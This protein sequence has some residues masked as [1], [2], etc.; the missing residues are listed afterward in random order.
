MANFNFKHGLSINRQLKAKPNYDCQ[1]WRTLVPLSQYHQCTLSWSDK[2]A[3][4]ELGYDDLAQKFQMTKKPSNEL[5]EQLK[6]KIDECK[7]IL[8]GSN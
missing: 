5:K 2:C 6:K 8:E 3:H 7:A 1:N 4:C